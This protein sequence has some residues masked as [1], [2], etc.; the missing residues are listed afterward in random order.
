[1]IGRRCGVRSRFAV[2]LWLAA[3]GGG[4]GAGAEDGPLEPAAPL[5]P[6]PPAPEASPACPTGKRCVALEASAP[7]ARVAEVFATAEPGTVIL[8]GPGT[9]RPSNTLA[10]AGEDVVVRG[11]GRDATVLDFGGQRVGSE[12]VLAEDARGLVL[13][14]F[15]V[16]DARGNGVKVLGAEGVVMRDLAVRWTS[17]DAGAHGPYGLY[18]V[19]STDVVVERCSVTGATDA[20]IYVGQSTGAVVRQNV[21]TGNVAGIEIENSFEVDV[22][23]NEAVGNAEGILVVD[24]PWV[25]LTGG[26]RIRVRDNLVADNNVANFSPKGSFVGSLPRGLGVLVMASRDVEVSRNAIRG[27]A[28]ANALVASF[29]ATGNTVEH[30]G[31]PSRVSLHDNRFEGGGDDPDRTRHLGAVLA[32]GTPAYP[33]GVVPAIVYDG[34]RDPARGDGANPH[35]ICVRAN[36]EATFATLNLDDGRRPDVARTVTFDPTPYDCALPPVVPETSAP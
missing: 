12:G 21:T 7:E 19:R 29:L 11:A 23:E 34:L 20:G 35:E 9:F 8:L 16:V 13:E 2:G 6:E 25:P 10:L 36:G 17:A 28:S 18:P 33:G 32:S 24:L 30:E 5:P 4:D 27:H 14:S 15:S 26:R 22:Y 1:M 31:Y 3:C